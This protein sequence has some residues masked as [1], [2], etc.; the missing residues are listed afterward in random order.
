MHLPRHL[1]ACSALFISALVSGFAQQAAPLQETWETGYSGKDATAAHVLGYWKFDGETDTALKDLS[2]KGN[3]LTLQGAVLNPQGKFG[4]ALEGFPGYPVEDKSHAARTQNQ[5]KLSPR[6]A[7][8]LEMWIRPKAEFA[9]TLRCFL[10]DKK[11]VDHVDYQWQIGEADK[12][13]LRRMWVNLGFGSE[14]KAITSNPMKLETDVWYHVAF[15]YDGNGSGTFY[16]NGETAGSMQLVG[17]GPVTPGN[18]PLTIGDRH[19]SNYGGFPGLIDEVRICDGIRHFG[20]AQ[21][22]IISERKVWRRMEKAK[23]AEIICTNLLRQKLKGAQLKISFANQNETYPV[24][25]LD[26]GKSYTVKFAINTAL[27]PEQYEL[28]TR[29]ELTEPKPYVLEQTQTLQITPRQP[30]RMPVVMWGADPS[31]TQ[32]L[33]DIGFTHCLGLYI[34]FSET[35]KAKKPMP[36]GSPTQIA[37]MR[38]MLD[39]ALANDLGVIASITPSQIPMKDPQY[40]RVDRNGKPYARED[41]CASMPEFSPYFENVGRSVAQTYGN[42]P[43]FAA[44]LV[45]SETRDSSQPSFNPVDIENYRNFSGQDIPPEVERR[46]GVD[47][48]KL[49]DFPQDR[50]IPDDHPILKYYRW[51]WTVGDGW[52]ALFSALHEGIKTANRPDLWTWF[53]PA[54]RQPG[55]SGGGGNVDV[56]SHWTYTYPQPQNIGLATDQLFAMSEATGRRQKVMKMTQVIWYR[57][58]T[59]PINP[60]TPG[61]TVAWEDHDP[62]AA[63]IT[64]APMHLR[65]A[66]WTKISRPVQGIM[67]HGWQ[68]LVPTATP[69][70]YRYTNPNTVHVLKELIHNVVEPLG[71]TLMRVPAHRSEVAFFESFTSQMFARRGGYGSNLTWA[72]DVWFA[73]QHSHI[74]PDILFE[75]VLLKDGLRGRKVLVMPE[76]DVLTTSVVNRIREWQKKGGK[77]VADEFLCPALKADV[78][79]TSFKRVKKGDEDKASILKLTET[80]RPQMHELGVAPAVDVDSPEIILHTRRYGDTT[81]IFAINDRREFGNYVGRAGLVMENGLPSSGTITSKLGQGNGNVYDLTRGTL[82]VP[83]RNGDNSLSWPVDLPPCD[84]RIY[85]VTSK[86]LLGL[87]LEVP[88]TAKLGNQATVRVTLTTSENAPLQAVLPVQVE[89][90]DTNGKPAEGSGYYAATDGVLSVNLDIAINEDPGT[91]TIRI[92]DLASGMES[93]KYLRV[94]K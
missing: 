13:G 72:T 74:Q 24:P 46:G 91:W 80:L 77:I 90:H 67:Y 17:Y 15:V 36:P 40:L 57:S 87:N 28:R 22:E 65:E 31:E 26:P 3:D 7:F 20:Q 73:L 35:W 52:N 60:G 1:L 51:F 2:G 11:Y 54:V 81:Y 41:I 89:I 23:P 6:G 27:K 14:S 45:S 88:A 12:A 16:L 61:N 92:R 56:I 30:E 76:C 25:E 93:V 34:D 8:T 63:Y 48:T 33:K 29:M 18:K 53:D 32:R 5:P 19:G 50:V 49:K 9:P 75:E 85:M 59:A 43:A 69:S 68:S 55:I 44:T 58:Q 10:L 47:W 37:K 78:V 70:G 84:G 4:A 94:E 66:F 64:I 21:L 42:H 79:L 82:I 86:P 38:A 71:P 62:D 39:E 83:K